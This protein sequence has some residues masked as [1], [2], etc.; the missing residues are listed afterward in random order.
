M[1]ISNVSYTIYNDVFSMCDS[2]LVVIKFVVVMTYVFCQDIFKSMPVSI[3][4]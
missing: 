1:G 2:F 4:R 3:R